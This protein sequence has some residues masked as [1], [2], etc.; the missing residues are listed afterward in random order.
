MS[1]LLAPTDLFFNECYVDLDS[2]KKMLTAIEYKWAYTTIRAIEILHSE[3]DLFS[4][5]L[6]EEE[7][8]NEIT[9]HTKLKAKPGLIPGTNKMELEISIDKKMKKLEGTYL[10][11]KMHGETYSFFRDAFIGP[12]SF[13]GKMDALRN[14]QLR[15]HKSRT[16]LIDENNAFIIDPFALKLEEFM[17]VTNE[18]LGLPSK[19][20]PSFETLMAFIQSHGE[21]A[22]QYG[23]DQSVKNKLVAYKRACKLYLE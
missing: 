17:Y 23:I 19:T 1:T 11:D 22:K 6:D 13:N 16:E 5:I 14:Y 8:N 18:I 9:Y 4:S 7:R 15:I 12:P 20:P 10:F 3:K 2:K 21:L